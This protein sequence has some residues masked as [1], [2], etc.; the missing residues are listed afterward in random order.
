[1]RQPPA[2][3]VGRKAVL[4][5]G[6]CVERA[7]ELEVH[8]L[9]ILRT[10]GGFLNWTLVNNRSAESTRDDSVT[11]HDILVWTLTECLVCLRT[12]LQGGDSADHDKRCSCACGPVPRRRLGRGRGAGKT[13][14]QTGPPFSC[15]FLHRPDKQ[16]MTVVPV[17][18]VGGRGAARCCPAPY[19]G[20]R[21]ALADSYSHRNAP[22]VLLLARPCQSHLPY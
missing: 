16:S 14:L 21:T 20:I 12:R 4:S 19:T 15:V 8:T 1:M 22:C 7:G 5:A 10:C 6:A 2:P 11:E 17:R 9:S 3:R 13:L 18:I